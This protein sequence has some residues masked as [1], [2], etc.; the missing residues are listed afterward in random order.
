MD[1]S[2]RKSESS[3]VLIVTDDSRDAIL[4]PGEFARLRSVQVLC[5]LSEKFSV[6]LTEIPDTNSM[7]AAKK[8]LKPCETK[9]PII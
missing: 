7:A 1:R 6:G 4:L 8:A 2:I 3:V 9:R 5:R